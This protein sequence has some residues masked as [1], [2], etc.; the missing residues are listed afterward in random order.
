M[1]DSEIAT[2]GSVFWER[3]NT[4]FSSSKKEER[5]EHE[6][7][8]HK[9]FVISMCILFSVVLW[10]FSSMSESYTRTFKI[11]TQILNLGENEA[12]V[13]LPPDEISVVITGEGLQLLQL[14]YNPPNLVLNANEERINVQDVV[15]GR[16]SQVM[17]VERTVPTYLTLKKEERVRKSVPILP[18]A[19]ISWPA[20]HDVLQ[21]V[22]LSPDSVEISGAQ[23]IVDVIKEWP[24]QFFE[25]E[26]V[27][28]SLF[29]DI[30]LADS[31]E[32]LIDL[33]IEETRLSVVTAQFTEGAREL[34]VDLKDVPSMHEAISLA[35]PN[36]EVRF[37]VPLFQYKMALEAED[38]LASVSY[39]ALRADTTGYITPQ[40][41]LP[42]GIWIRDVVMD[43]PKLR[44]YDILIDE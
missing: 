28:D 31:L 21:D 30:P 22:L 32:G 3:L 33:G 6:Q 43:P 23:S 35:P 19:T 2:Y 26:D 20:T 9:G 37:R 14:F 15:E 17:R 27:K 1:A 38:F 4:I 7:P 18:R 10:I 41:E 42:H 16:I 11:P 13:E 44:Y 24:T 8:E 5:D 12:F 34:D 39:D 40:L 29:V 36:I 25:K